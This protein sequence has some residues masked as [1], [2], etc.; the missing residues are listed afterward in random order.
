MVVSHIWCAR[1]APFFA[2][3]VAEMEAF[4]DAQITSQVNRNTRQES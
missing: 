3:G 4:Q 2:P 1:T